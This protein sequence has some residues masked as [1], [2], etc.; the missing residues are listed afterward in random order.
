MIARGVILQCLF[1][2]GLLSFLP[3]TVLPERLTGQTVTWASFDYVNSVASSMS[4]VYF[5]TTEGIIRYNKMEQ[6]WEGPLTGA[7]GLDN[8]AVKGIWVDTFDEE[9]YIQT[10][11]DRFQYSV[12]FDSW[13]PVMEIPEIRTNSHKVGV[14]TGIFPPVEYHILNDGRL[15]DP[16]GR[17]YVISDVV[18]DGTG[19][20]WYGTWGH[21][22]GTSDGPNGQLELLPYGLIQNRVDAIFSDGSRLWLGG[23]SGYSFRTGLSVFSIENNSFSYVESGLDNS[24][25]A[26]DVW[27]FEGNQKAV[28]IGTSY[29]LFVYDRNLERITDRVSGRNGL[30]SDEVLGLQLVGDSLFVGTDEGLTLLDMAS[31]SIGYIN[32]SEFLNRPVYD[33]ALV[34]SVLWI[35]ADGGGYRLI[36]TTGKLQQ[37]QDPE[38][39]IFRTAYAVEAYGESVW[40]ASDYGIV[41]LNT[42]TGE[43][44]AYSDGTSVYRT[45]ALAV[46]DRVAAVASDYGFTLFFMD[47]GKPVSREFTTQDGL[48]SGN[49]L[50][51]LMDGDYLWVGTDQGLTRFLWN[52]PDR[53]D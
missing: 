15:T 53:I 50:S 29:G 38:R 33:F 4:H 28:Y 17:S 39:V 49:V 14:P 20:L 37:F 1:L 45:R 16:F 40:L 7:V 2:A 25:P 12:F 23:R 18:D 21:G 6:R 11:T 42:R 35:A 47:R 46:N 10:E 51:L 41:H 52:N 22:T 5:A 36:L 43:T 27:C 44:R 9:L 13:S 32:P 24:F 31:D 3:S 34:D 8:E 30:I 19:T 26:E 48:P